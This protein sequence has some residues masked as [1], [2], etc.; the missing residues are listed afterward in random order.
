MSDGEPTNHPPMTAPADPPPV[1]RP[2]QFLRDVLFGWLTG[3][4][5][6]WAVYAAANLLARPAHAAVTARD[7]AV[8]LGGGLGAFVTFT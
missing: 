6:A 3:F 5:V 8:Q 7:L 4:V 1:E 2:P